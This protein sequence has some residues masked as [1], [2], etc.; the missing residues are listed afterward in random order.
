MNEHFDMLL[1]DFSVSQPGGAW[2]VLDGVTCRYSVSVERVSDPMFNS[3]AWYDE[4]TCRVVGMQIGGLE[5]DRGEV[6][7]I[8][9]GS[10]MR[11]D[12]LDDA[13]FQDYHSKRETV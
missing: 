11:L 1:E 2:A 10:A 4:A 8:L 12:Q 13:A 6:L 5:L 3:G 9:G 7:A